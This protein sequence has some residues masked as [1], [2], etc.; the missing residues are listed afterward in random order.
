MCEPPVEQ[1]AVHRRFWIA[2]CRED[3]PANRTELAP[4]LAKFTAQRGGHGHDPFTSLF[5]C[6]SAPPD[7]TG[8]PQ[9]IV[10]AELANRPEAPASRLAK[11]ERQLHLDPSSPLALCFRLGSQPAHRHLRPAFRPATFHPILP[12]RNRRV[13][14]DGKLAV[15]KFASS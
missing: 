3:P 4:K 8:V 6:L 5:V 14:L 10:P 12:L 2:L 13:T 7:D 1:V 15:S 11:H 9:Y